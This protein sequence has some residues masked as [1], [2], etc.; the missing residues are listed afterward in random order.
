[1][2]TI[3]KNVFNYTKVCNMEPLTYTC[4]HCY[5]V[6]YVDDYKYFVDEHGRILRDEPKKVACI[7]CGKPIIITVYVAVDVKFPEGMEDE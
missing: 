3:V 7:G 5:G 1:M 2:L 6:Y 4:L